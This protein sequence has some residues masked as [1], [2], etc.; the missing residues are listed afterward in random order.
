MAC[1]KYQQYR[2][3][4]NSCYCQKHY[5]E[6][7]QN[8]QGTE[9]PRSTNSVNGHNIVSEWSSIQKDELHLNQ[10][11]VK[12]SSKNPVNAMTDINGIIFNAT[13]SILNEKL[14]VAQ[15]TAQPRNAI[16]TDMTKNINASIRVLH[17][18]CF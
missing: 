10:T 1:E 12:P 4:K 5:N 7:L 2:S 17:D 14:I 3:N 8:Q 18:D 13:A 9:Q 11:T 6:F 16:P 15:A